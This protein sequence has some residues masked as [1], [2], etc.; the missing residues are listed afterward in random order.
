MNLEETKS[1]MASKGVIGGIM[2]G[3]F[4][5]LSISGVEIS[6]TEQVAITEGIFGMLAAISSLIAAWGRIVATKQIVF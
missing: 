3:V 5:I 6:I 1:P 2:G 4:A